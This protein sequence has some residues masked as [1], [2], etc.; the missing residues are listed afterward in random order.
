MRGERDE[1]QADE[2]ECA[3]KTSKKVINCV[4]PRKVVLSGNSSDDNLFGE[5]KIES[6]EKGKAARKI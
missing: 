6:D 3:A 4:I 2:K 5:E 1:R